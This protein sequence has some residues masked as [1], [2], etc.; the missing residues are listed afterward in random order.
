MSTIITEISLDEFWSSVM[1]S[2]WDSDP[3]TRCWV[4]RAVFKQ[5]SWNEL[6]TL[7][8]TYIPE[9]KDEDCPDSELLT[10]DITIHELVNALHLAISREL[11]H[12]G[13][14]VGYDLWSYDSCV[15]D[16]LFQLAVYG[17]EVWA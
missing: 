1:G 3:L 4:R 12:C 7:E 15:A 8:L 11:H 16:I 6:G 5:G 13:E 10:K 17:K 9:D 14:S 2:G